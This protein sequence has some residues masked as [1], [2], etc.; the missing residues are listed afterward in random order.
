MTTRVARRCEPGTP[1]D[2]SSANTR[3]MS[4]SLLTAHDVLHLIFQYLLPPPPIVEGMKVELVSHRWL[5]DIAV[6][7]KS[8]SGHAL[9][10]LWHTLPSDEPLLYL[11][12]VLGITVLNSNVTGDHE[13]QGQTTTRSGVS[14]VRSHSRPM[15]L[16]YSPLL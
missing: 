14:P 2:D 11:L 9:D 7:C 12:D 16:Y 1:V 10:V 8:L 5:L 3:H 13:W 15:Q 4:Q 6:S